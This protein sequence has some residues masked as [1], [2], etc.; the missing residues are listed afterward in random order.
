MKHLTR[1]S[2]ATLGV[3]VMVGGV[4]IA[5]FT[6]AHSAL[7]EDVPTDG[8]PTSQPTEGVVRPPLYSEGRRLAAER[9][10]TGAVHQTATQEGGALQTRLQDAQLRICQAHEKEITGIMNRLSERGQKQ[11]DMFATIAERAEAFYVKQG[12]PLANYDTLVADVASKKVATQS[13]ID[14]LK[15]DSGTFQCAGDNPRGAIQRFKDA[16]K[17]EITALTN[18]RA[19]VKNLIVGIKSVQGTTTKEAK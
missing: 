9:Q 8:T 18:Y 11:A 1:R 6:L 19:S 14:A 12:K 10:T 5:S 3:L 4:G 17:S 2:V 7:A 16:L 15:A 13:T